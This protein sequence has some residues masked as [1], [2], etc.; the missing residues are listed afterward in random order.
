MKYS[1]I[2]HKHYHKFKPEESLFILSKGKNAGKVLEKPCPNCFR[3]T[4]EPKDIE[5]IKACATALF[6]SERLKR[7]L[8]G[9][10]ISFI[11]IVHYKNFLH[12][13]VRTITDKPQFIAKTDTIA[14]AIEL[15]KK[16]NEIGKTYKI[17]QV[18]IANELL[19]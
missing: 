12:V 17:L 1:V 9:A 16:Y 14:K 19:K 4:A 6:H 7:I 3:I 15:V 2:T 13:A 10:V 5:F 8:R 11:T 18:S